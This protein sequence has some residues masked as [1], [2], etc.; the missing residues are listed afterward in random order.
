ME[1]LSIYEYKDYKRLILDWMERNPN[2]GRGQRKQLAVAIDCQ[3]P[4]IT[5]VLSGDYHFSLEQ[6]EKCA[7]WMGLNEN[8]SEF[9]VLLVLKQRSSTRGLDQMISRLISKRREAE[10]V[11][12]KRLNIK[13]SLS[14]EDQMLYYTNWHYGAIHMACLIPGMQNVEALQRHFG[15][16]TSQV[17]GA[18]EFLTEH[19]LIEKTKAFYKVLQPVL[20]LGKDSPLLTQHHTQWRLRAIDQLQKKT[21]SDLFYSGV[22][23]LSRE[24]YEW[25]RERLTVLL[26][27]AVERLKSSKDE[28]LACFNFD[29]FE[30]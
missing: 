12:K 28:T 13:T 30:I 22:M 4:F 16:T 19:Q 20:H 15:L 8:D 17:I 23:S 5:H 29:L 11:L 2:K 10:T 7:R 18:L 27:E 25:L 3:T 14:L 24:D 21:A 6:A 26:S 9:F 1:R